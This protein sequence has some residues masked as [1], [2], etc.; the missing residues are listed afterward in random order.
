MRRVLIWFSGANPEILARFPSDWAK[1]QGIGSAVLT[2]AVMAGL[3][4]GFALHMA[5]KLAIP[6]CVILGS[7]WGVA[8]M[9]L[10]RWLVASVQRREHWYQNL[11]LALPRLGLAVLIGLVIS[12]PFVLRIFQLEIEA[13]LVD[14][15]R[16]RASEFND[17]MRND[18]RATQI[19]ELQQQQTA[20]QTTVNSGGGP[21]VDVS[22]DPEVARLQD[23]VRQANDR[24]KTAQDNVVCEK[25]GTCGSG[26][27]GAG[28]AFAE[29][30]AIR[31]RA[32]TELDALQGQLDTA[33]SA[34]R[35]ANASSRTA[36]ATTATQ[37]L[38]KV[39]EQIKGLAD[40]LQAAI[41]KFSRENGD[42]TGLLIRIEALDRLTSKRPTLATVHMLLLLFFTAFECLPILVKFLLSLGPATKYETAVAV[43][44]ENRLDTEREL[45]RRRRATVL[46]NESDALLEAQV[47]REAKDEVIDRLTRST[48][49]AQAELAE[50]VL[51]QWKRQEMG[52]VRANPGAYFSS[53]PTE[54]PDARIRSEQSGFRPPPREPRQDPSA[55]AGAGAAGP[56]GSGGRYGPARGQGRP[57]EPPRTNRRPGPF[58]PDPS[59]R[60]PRNP[61]PRTPEN[62]DPHYEQRWTP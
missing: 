23:L 41:D 31:D 50:E 57:S 30:V 56:N 54:A 7:A 14:I 44:E 48:I 18:S 20:L 19:T 51:K 60:P 42:D 17:A 32:K 34:A 13:Q 29:K 33:I 35:D 6:G 61:R 55:G 10:D 16:E 8:I 11:L 5:L 58:G 27:V 39:N 46:L 21:A 52:R 15:H 45:A 53:G 9:S 43:D 3:S 2:T 38:N 62:D 28:I 40:D 12:T 37:Q 24:Y 4:C 22:K 47:G 25:E 36:N 59:E 49:A 26:R 1:Y